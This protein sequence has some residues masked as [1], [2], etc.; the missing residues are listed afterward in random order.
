MTDAVK[1]CIDD[2]DENSETDE[3]F[4]ERAAEDGERCG[5]VDDSAGNDKADSEDGRIDLDLNAG[6]RAI[7]SPPDSTDRGGR[8]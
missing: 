5:L 4:D 7:D 2:C 8:E 1:D 3:Q 6:A